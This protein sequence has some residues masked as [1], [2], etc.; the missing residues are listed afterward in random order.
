MLYHLKP[1]VL[2]KTYIMPDNQGPV[3]KEGNHESKNG[4][5]NTGKTFI[6]PLAVLN[7]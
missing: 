6:N 3:P 5:N 4:S 7:D 1:S 2:H